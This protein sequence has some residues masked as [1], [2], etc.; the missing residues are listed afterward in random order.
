ML[1]SYV[2]RLKSVLQTRPPEIAA[3]LRDF[4]AE[5]SKLRNQPDQ[6]GIKIFF[7]ARNARRISGSDA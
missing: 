7:N 6:V 3:G 4:T 2:F 1:D 5:S